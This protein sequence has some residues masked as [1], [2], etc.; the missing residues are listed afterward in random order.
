[1]KRLKGWDGLL[2]YSETPNVHQHTLKVAVVDT[3]AFEGEPGF[4]ASAETLR[5]RLHVLEPLRYQLVDIPLHLHPPMW[6]EEAEVDLD[7]HLHRVK[8]P[9]PGGRRELIR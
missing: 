5:R 1:M 4:D 3:A 6:L 9:A 2:L 8:V 7:Y